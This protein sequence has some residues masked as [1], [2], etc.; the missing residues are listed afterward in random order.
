MVSALQG[1]QPRHEA[2]PLRNLEAGPVRSVTQRAV[3]WRTR[4]RQGCVTA[5]AADARALGACGHRAVFEVA[6]LLR[7]ELVSRAAIPLPPPSPF[8][9]PVKNFLVKPRRPG[10]NKR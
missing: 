4:A 6:V 8:P 5:R 3:Q 7:G 1:V 10:A 9:E 2:R